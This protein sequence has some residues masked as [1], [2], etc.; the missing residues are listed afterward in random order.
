MGN[1]EGEGIILEIDNGSVFHPLVSYV[2]G[3]LGCRAFNLMIYAAYLV[4]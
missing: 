2:V 1:R 3:E 4:H